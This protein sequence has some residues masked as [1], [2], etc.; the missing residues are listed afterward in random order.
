VTLEFEEGSARVVRVPVDIGYR[1]LQRS[2]AA[3]GYVAAGMQADFLQISGVG[4]QRSAQAF[5][6]GLGARAALGGRY[7]VHAVWA[8]FAEVSAVYF[9][10]PYRLEVEPVQVLGSTPDAWLGVA[11]GAALWTTASD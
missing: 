9:P 10:R 4:Y 7:H 11:L 6:V 1:L 8:V 3:S 5:R 2:G